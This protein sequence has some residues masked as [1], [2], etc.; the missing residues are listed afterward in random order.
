MKPEPY[1]S[2]SKPLRR[3]TLMWKVSS[4][5]LLAVTAL[6]LCLNALSR[7]KHLLRRILLPD[8]PIRSSHMP[9]YR[10]L[11]RA[12]KIGEFAE[13]P[14]LPNVTYNSGHSIG[15]HYPLPRAYWR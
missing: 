15:R 14:A 5:F 6:L 13:C 8:H 2:P 7:Q 12:F 9:H 10:P 1:P 3:S 4:V 11:M